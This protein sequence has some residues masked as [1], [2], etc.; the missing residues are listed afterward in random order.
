MR[1]S[2][3]WTATTIGKSSLIDIWMAS[4]VDESKLLYHIASVY[5]FVQY[6]QKMRIHWNAQWTMT[7]LVIR[8]LWWVFNPIVRAMIWRRN[9]LSGVT[10]SRQN[11]TEQ[12]KFYKPSNDW[13]SIALPQCE[14]RRR[15]NYW[16]G[17][18]LFHCDVLTGA[19]KQCHLLE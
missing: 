10:T 11:L 9:V 18:Q 19:K 4:D 12:T 1:K 3:K 7:N 16:Y 13:L 17:R 14:T 2:N 5:M 15:H 8:R 6:R